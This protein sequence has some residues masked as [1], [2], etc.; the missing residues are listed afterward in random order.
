MMMGFDYFDQV[1]DH[2]HSKLRQLDAADLYLEYAN[3]WAAE[4]NAYPHCDQRI[5]HSPGACEFCDLAKVLQQYRAMLHL[6]FT[7]QLGENDPL[8]PGET[9]TKASAERWGGNR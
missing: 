3:N 8:L 4:G 7:D 5:L 2:A 9:R 1:L 6:K